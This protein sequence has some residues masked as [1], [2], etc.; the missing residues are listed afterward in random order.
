MAN[1]KYVS[2]RYM[3][4]RLDLYEGNN[5]GGRP[6]DRFTILTVVTVTAHPVMIHYSIQVLICFI[7]QVE[8]LMVQSASTDVN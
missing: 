2:I 5:L 7:I 4:G 3:Q 1:P 6:L 8:T